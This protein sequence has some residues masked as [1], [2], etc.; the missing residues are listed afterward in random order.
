MY[1]IG[2]VVGAG[3]GVLAGLRS[4]VD[5]LLAEDPRAVPL[6]DLVGDIAGLHSQM[7]RLQAVMLSMVR[8]CDGDGGHHVAGFATTGSM[9]TDGLRLTPG[10]GQAMVRTARELPPTFPAVWE[11]LR[12]GDISVAHAA[13]V[14][15][16]RKKVPADHLEA[17]EPLLLD[18]ARVGSPSMVRAAVDRI[19]DLLDPQEHDDDLQDAFARRNLSV[20]ET[21]DGWWAVD[22]HL[23]P[24]IGARLSAA[25]EEF[26]APLGLADTRTAEQRRADAIGEIA[27]AAV[28]GETTGL[29][30]V[31]IVADADRMDGVGAMW[32]ASGLPVGLT[33]FDMAVCQCTVRLVVATASGIGWKPIAVGMAARFA[34]PAQRAALTVRDRGCV[35][36]GCTRPP[37]RCHAHHVIDW[38]DAGP[39]DVDNLVFLCAYHHRMVHLGRAVLVDDPHI[40]GRRI[41]VP[42]RRHMTTAA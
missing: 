2:G 39:T 41:A 29:S 9:L 36:R 23:P 18:V 25:L 30:S 7:Q 10:Q 15:R 38:R 8:V 17:A 35:F 40:P 22:G 31:V 24:E 37:R 14:C 13:A 3:S 19:A 20:S 26:A 28:D 42:A 32:D 16:A 1:E 34:T 5:V 21:L 6:T 12:A 33:T 4:A 11:A 27:D